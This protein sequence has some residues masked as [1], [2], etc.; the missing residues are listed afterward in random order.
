V[1]MTKMSFPIRFLL[2]LTLIAGLAGGLLVLGL[3]LMVQLDRGLRYLPELYRNYQEERKKADEMSCASPTLKQSL[4]FKTRV[5][6]KLLS[7]QM[8]L[9]Q[10]VGIFRNVH[11]ALPLA[12]RVPLSGDTPEEKYGG[13]VLAW[14]RIEREFYSTHIPERVV[15]SLEAELHKLLSGPGGWIPEVSP[16]T[17]AELLSPGSPA[18]M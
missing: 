9:R 6:Q 5:T 3:G 1:E 16:E 8:T 17:I 13:N 11:E 2:T 7:G 4:L 12:A 14:A 15:Q 10:A 18:E